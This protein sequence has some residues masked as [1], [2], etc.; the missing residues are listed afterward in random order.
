MAGHDVS[1]QHKP[2]NAEFMNSWHSTSNYK[3]LSHCQRSYLQFL[4]IP[5]RE[6]VLRPGTRAHFRWISCAPGRVGQNHCSPGLGHGR[7]LLGP[8][9]GYCERALCNI[10]LPLYIFKS[11]HKEKFFKNYSSDIG[12][13]M[14]SN[15]HLPL[16]WSVPDTCVAFVFFRV[17]LL[18]FIQLII[19]AII[20]NEKPFVAI[21]TLVVI[22]KTQISNWL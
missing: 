17:C 9:G 7:C 11:L 2:K 20:F 1:V 12:S 13:A 10:R 4:A 16:K 15:T 21:Y 22:A 8:G 19:I 14:F 6:G 3:I 18:A 5:V